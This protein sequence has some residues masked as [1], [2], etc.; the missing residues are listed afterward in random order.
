MFNLFFY[1][2]LNVTFHKMGEGGVSVKRQKDDI[3]DKIDL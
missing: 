2:N 3:K 1:M